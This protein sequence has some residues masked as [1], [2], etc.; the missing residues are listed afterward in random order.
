MGYSR[1][2]FEVVGVDIKPQPHY[3]F[4][5]W[6]AD[7]LQVLLT[8]SWHEFDVIHASPPCQRY[9]RGG[10]QNDKH[11]DL[12]PKVR[13]LLARLSTPSVLENVPGAP[14]Q[15]DV[16]LCGSMFGL[17]LRRHRWFEGHPSLSPWTMGCN[18]EGPIY[19]VYG[20]PHGQAGAW[21][22]MLPDTIETRQKALGIDWT[23]DAQSLA[24]AIPPAYTEWIGT[25][26]LE[27]L[28]RHGE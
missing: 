24:D 9:I 4:E 12:L 26:L 13:T 11:P 8:G 6:E 16:L 17:Q 15:P 27:V 18:H 28:G 20:H 21:P 14:M 1:A 7:A 3:P 5:F 25:R 2:G 22:G 19:G 10:L 23:E